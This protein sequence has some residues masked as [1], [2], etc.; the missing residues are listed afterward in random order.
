MPG[1]ERS[2]GEYGYVHMYGWVPSLFTWNY[3]HCSLIGY[4]LI[5]N[6]MFK[7]KKNA[8]IQQSGYLHPKQRGLL[9]S[10][11]LSRE[12][13]PF[14]TVILLLDAWLETY[15]P[16]ANCSQCSPTCREVRGP[17]QSKPHPASEDLEGVM[18][19]PTRTSRLQVLPSNVAGTQS[20]QPSLHLL[21][22]S[23]QTFHLTL[24]CPFFQYQGYARL[25]V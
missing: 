11:E 16:I 20:T 7:K 3:Q 4:T 21:T 9:R 19:S 15:S 1:W 13:L 8:Y 5:Q 22:S 6:K 23:D 12:S 24:F 10:P 18:Q 14:S 2:L 25:S 17:A